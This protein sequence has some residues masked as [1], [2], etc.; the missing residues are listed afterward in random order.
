M[1]LFDNVD[2]HETE[3]FKKLAFSYN[4]ILLRYPPHFTHLM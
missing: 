1:L 4:I 2:S 3:E